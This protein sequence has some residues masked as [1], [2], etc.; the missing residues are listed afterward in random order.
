MQSG[1]AFGDGD[2]AE[3]VV[4]SCP[5]RGLE[6]LV[7]KL[8]PLPRKPQSVRRQEKAER[9]SKAHKKISESSTANGRKARRL[10]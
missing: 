9:A 10:A 7:R 5:K 1:S 4:L 6:A 2:D 3:D 8:F